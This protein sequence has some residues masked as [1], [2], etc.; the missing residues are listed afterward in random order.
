MHDPLSPGPC[1]P[2]EL[3]LR[4]ELLLLDIRTEEERLGPL[5]FV[6]ASVHLPED[7]GFLYALERLGELLRGCEGFV[8]ICQSDRRA[9]LLQERH[10]WLLGRPVYWMEGGLLGWMRAGLPLVGLQSSA[11]L[12]LE[13]AQEAFRALTS[14]FAAEVIESALNQNHEPPDPLELLQTCFA[15]EGVDP[16][17][18]DPARLPQVLDRAAAFSRLAGT[19]L[20]R[21]RDNLD[22]FRATLR[23]AA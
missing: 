17:A 18:P 2:L 12:P 10:P 4:P 19:P 20:D 9:R 6:P 11:A 7:A 15:A 5:G 22:V 1:D 16:Q 8:L 14:C 23:V 3:L 13:S 21:I